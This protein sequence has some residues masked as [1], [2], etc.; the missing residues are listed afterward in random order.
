MYLFFV[1]QYKLK[2]SN[3][4][5]SLWRAELTAVCSFYGISML[6]KGTLPVAAGTADAPQA[7]LQ[8]LT[9]HWLA[10]AEDRIST[11]IFSKEEKKTRKCA[12][13]WII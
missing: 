11:L 7:T 10:S 4:T 3:H 9:H 13:Q 8:P 12:Y 5:D 6:L 1:T 2:Q